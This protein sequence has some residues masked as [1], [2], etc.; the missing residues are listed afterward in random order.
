MPSVKTKFVWN[1]DYIKVQGKKVINKSIF[2]V[3]LIVE[4]QAKLLAAVQYGYLAA[5]ITTQSRTEGTDLGSPAEYSSESVP[6]GHDVASFKLI[7]KPADDNEV[8]V[9][10]AVDYGPYIEFGTVKMAAQPFLRPSLD[11]AKG[12]TLS[13]VKINSK[14]YFGDYLNARDIFLSM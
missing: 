13:I 11:L 3:G 9:G 4:G 7:G 5:S 12:K 14:Y 8:F 1:G 2:E 6:A 10:T